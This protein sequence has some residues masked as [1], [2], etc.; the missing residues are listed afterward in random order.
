MIRSAA[1]TVF[2][3]SLS[4]QACLQSGHKPQAVATSHL[5]AGYFIN[6]SG[7]TIRAVVRT[8][9]EWKAQLD[10][11]AFY[12][13]REKGTERAFSGPYNTNKRKG[14]YL[15]NGCALPLFSSAAKFDSGTGWPSFTAPVDT[16]HVLEISDHSF[17]MRR[18]EVLCRR[19]G[20][21]LGHVF[22]DGP[23]PTGIRYC[24]NSVSLTFR[25]E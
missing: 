16:T 3:L 11:S 5:P 7:D 1:L 10:P 24:M 15:C 13:L 17:G 23:R 21:H 18:V 19:C 9:Q 20:G 14:T 25:E 4:L 12:V 22:D 2:L 6:S 8:D